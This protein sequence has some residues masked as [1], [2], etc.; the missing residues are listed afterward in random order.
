MSPVLLLLL[1]GSPQ[2]PAVS[3]AAEPWAMVR[4]TLP[5][6]GAQRGS[7]MWYRRPVHVVS[8]DGP[9]VQIEALTPMEYGPDG[10]VVGHVRY[11]SQL[12]CGTTNLRGV[13]GPGEAVEPWGPPPP[14][15]SPPYEFIRAVCDEKRPYDTAASP[16]QALEK[17]A[18]N[19]RRWRL[20]V[21]M[22]RTRP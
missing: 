16:E 11:V 21:E 13:P 1:L 6:P 14:E 18:E 12:H 15:F 20:R 22:G 9:I 10:A 17:S 19:E 3:A 2:D 4:W 5:M 7:D 8:E